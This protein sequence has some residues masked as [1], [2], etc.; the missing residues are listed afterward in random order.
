MHT[1]DLT[2]DDISKIEGKA[3]L[4]VK[5][6]DDTIEEIQ[7]KITEYKRFYTQAIRGK[8]IAA[9][10]Q[11]CARVCGT[12]SNAH[13][14]CAIK[15][16]EN[17]L[18]ITPS[19]QTQKLRELLNFGLNIRDHALHLYVFVL[20]DL[21]GIDSILDLDENKPEEREL[22]EDTFSVKS[23]GN[24]LSKVIG[25]RSVHA[26]FPTIGGFLIVPKQELF[27]GLIKELQE[28]R[29]AVLRLIERFSNYSFLLAQSIQFVSLIDSD[30]SFLKG[31]IITSDGKVIKETNVKKYLEHVVIPYSHASGY[32]FAGKT[33]FVGA[34]SRINLAKKYLHKNTIK[35]AGSI[36]DRFPSENAYDNNLAQAI[37]ILHCIDKS[38]DILENLKVEKEPP[39]PIVRK[40]C[41]GVGV[42]E[43]PRGMLFYRLEMDNVGKIINADLVVP[44]GQNQIGIEK[45]LYAYISANIQ[46]DQHELSHDIEKIIRAYDPCMSCASHFLKVKWERLSAKRINNTGNIFN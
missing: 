45:T 8:D 38:I 21:L 5:I 33:Y 39:I 32:T 2:L 30:Y 24:T 42:I 35:D 29:P 16:I 44:T 20:P 7:F 9:I 15:A 28:V 12:C 18:G 40:E 31:E 3:S 10:P 37:E 11:L 13:L 25:G 6:K 14:L 4:S 34:L 36:L 41:V 17:G 19:S 46:K 1:F 27:E 43:A 23:A 26:P 22:L